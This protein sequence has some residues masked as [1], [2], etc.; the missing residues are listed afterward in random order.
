M[1]EQQLLLQTFA[2]CQAQATDFFRL[3][4][5]ALLPAGQPRGLDSHHRTHGRPFSPVGIPLALVQ[6]LAVLG[7]QGHGQ[8]R[9][10]ELP[11]PGREEKTEAGTW[12]PGKG[13][14]PFS[15][16][17]PVSLSVPVLTQPLLPGRQLCSQ[18]RGVGRSL[19]CVCSQ[20]HPRAWWRGR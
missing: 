15:P 6:E 12:G 19:T 5:T 8:Q 16:P 10:L 1:P 20:P 2:T 9:L 11:D 14:D 18:T 17:I 3:L 7:L 4:H 13:K